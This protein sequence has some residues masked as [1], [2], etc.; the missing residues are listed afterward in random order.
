MCRYEESPHSCFRGPCVRVLY[1]LIGPHF[2]LKNCADFF[3]CTLYAYD[4]VSVLRFKAEI[5]DSGLSPQV[6]IWASSGPNLSVLR[7][8]AEISGPDP[9]PEVQIWVQGW[10]LMSRSEHPYVQIWVSSGSKLSPQVQTECTQV[11]SLASSC[12]KLSVLRLSFGFAHMPIGHD[13]VP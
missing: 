3:L 12:S 6:Q 13:R 9:S 4:K 8:K 11:E 10:A 1:N 7:F 2:G 5:S